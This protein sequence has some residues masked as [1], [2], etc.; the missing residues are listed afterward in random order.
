M[1]YAAM[2][3]SHSINQKTKLRKLTQINRL[4]SMMMAPARRSTPTRA[5][6]L[7]NHLMPLDMYLH[8]FSPVVGGR[9]S[10]SLLHTVRN[11]LLEIRYI[12]THNPY[13]LQKIPALARNLWSLRPV[14]EVLYSWHSRER[15]E[16]LRFP[17][18][19]VKI[20]IISI[21]PRLP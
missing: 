4:A 6:E 17:G 20:V 7:I 11:K 12:S 15:Q 8:F 16:V 21:D 13:A 2:T 19:R 14:K 1:S 5:L 9:A 18:V 3:W 10:Q